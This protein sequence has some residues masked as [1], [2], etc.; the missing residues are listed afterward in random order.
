MNRGLGG[1]ILHPS[2]FILAGIIQRRPR[3]P[4]LMVRN[5]LIVIV[6][7]AAL[8]AG[9]DIALFTD[10]RSMKVDG[11]KVVSDSEIQLTLKNGGK[12]TLPINR[13]ERI[14]DDEVVSV[15]VVAE[16]KKTVEH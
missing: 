12:M 5:A 15:E 2:A 14:I 8:P 11:Y 10:G 7:L 1:F 3:F 6:A 9:A 13:L 16:I 4:A